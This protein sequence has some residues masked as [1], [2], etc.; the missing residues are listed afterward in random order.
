MTP[1]QDKS[2]EKRTESNKIISDK[3]LVKEEEWKILDVN[4]QSRERNGMENSQN[5]RT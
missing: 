1:A 4:E 2:L 3:L 5:W